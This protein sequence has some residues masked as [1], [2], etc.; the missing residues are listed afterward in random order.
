[1]AR[2]LEVRMGEVKA[3]LAEQAAEVSRHRNRI[4]ILAA[5]LAQ[6]DKVDAGLRTEIARLEEQVATYEGLISQRTDSVSATLERL[7]A[8][9]SQIAGRP[10]RVDVTPLP[11]EHAGETPAA[12]AR[13][14]TE[15]TLA[16]PLV[17]AAVEIFGAEVRGVRD[18]SGS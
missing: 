4:E 6:R 7:Q 1:M 13:R 3:K 14:R 16:D 9:A 18:R 12:Q 15:E 17:Q 8:I 10:L 11:A 2:K 5:D